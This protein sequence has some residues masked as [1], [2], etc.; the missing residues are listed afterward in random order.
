MN[1]V[2][3]PKP[4]SGSKNGS[5]FVGHEPV[6]PRL[7][8]ALRDEGLTNSPEP[9]FG[10]VDQPLRRRLGLEQGVPAYERVAPRVRVV[11]RGTSASIS[12]TELSVPSTS[13]SS[14]TLK[15]C[16][17]FIPFY[18]RSDDLPYSARAPGASAARDLLVSV[19]TDFAAWLR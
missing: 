9:R 6:S 3:L 8:E 2:R 18:P 10:R 15:M 11:H 16:W 7:V 12:Y 17:W 4:D 1:P 5:V 13:R 14:R 19:T